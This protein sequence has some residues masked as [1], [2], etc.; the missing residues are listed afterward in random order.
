M[1]PDQKSD[2]LTTAPPRHPY[3]TRSAFPAPS[4][5]AMTNTPPVSKPRSPPPPD[6]RPPISSHTLIPGACRPHGVVDCEKCVVPRSATHHYQALIAIRQDCGL[7]HPVIA[8]ACQ[9][10]CKDTNVPVTD[11]L[12]ENQPLRILRDTGC[13]TVIARGSPVSETKL[14]GQEA[15]CVLIDG[16]IHRAPV[17]QVFRDKIGRAS[18]RER[19]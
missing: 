15:K 6:S 18:C 7:Q 14:T 3:G 1:T 12:L 2:A 8:D 9:S 11:G 5:P 4:G 10:D 13:S 19:V 17:V 16:T